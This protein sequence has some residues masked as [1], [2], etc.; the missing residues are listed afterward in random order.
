MS[1]IVRPKLILVT[2]MS[3]AGR[4]TALRAMEDVG[5]D[6]VDNLPLSLL[7]R[8]AAYEAKTHGTDRPLAVGIDIRRRDFSIEAIEKEMDR[9]SRKSPYDLSV[10][11]IDCDEQTLIGRFKE[12]RRPHPLSQDRPV[13]D[14]IRL[15]QQMMAPLRDR[16]DRVIDT[17]GLTIWQFR[18]KISAMFGSGADTVMAI[19]VSSF[20]FRKGIP[21]DAGSGL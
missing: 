2:G 10:L 15:E 13:A 5:F 9:L 12:T 8:L 16:A 3:G 19:S 7:S 4:T 18:E 21:R 1:D 17:S 20:S 14:G 11:Y 6:V